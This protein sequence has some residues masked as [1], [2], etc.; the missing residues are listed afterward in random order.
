MV[1]YLSNKQYTFALSQP[2]R[3]YRRP[4][5]VEPLSPSQSYQCPAQPVLQSNPL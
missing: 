2:L 3:N 4:V 5:L 1:L